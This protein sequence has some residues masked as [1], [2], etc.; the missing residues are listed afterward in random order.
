MSLK[1]GDI[2]LE[3]NQEYSIVLTKMRNA[4]EEN[5]I[6][7]RNL[8]DTIINFW[9]VNRKKANFIVNTLEISGTATVVYT[10]VKSMRI[11]D[12]DHIPLLLSGKRFVYDE[13]ICTRVHMLEVPMVKKEEIKKEL[14]EEI[15]D[16]L[17]IIKEYGDIITVLPLRYYYGL[18]NYKEYIKQVNNMFLDFFDDKYQSMEEYFAANVSVEDIKNNINI[19][20][21]NHLM[22]VS[23]EGNKTLE[24]KVNGFYEGV[25]F[26]ESNNDFG[27]KLYFACFSLLSQALDVFLTCFAC[28]F[29]PFIRSHACLSNFIIL[30]SNMPENDYSNIIEKMIINSTFSFALYCETDSDE[31]LSEIEKK[32]D[33][34][35]VGCYYDYYQKIILDNGIRLDNISL[36]FAFELSKRFI[37]GFLNG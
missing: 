8:I 1:L 9:N 29:T 15:D 3:L 26:Y 4:L 37:D 13:T 25:S 7:P 27:K 33:D 36:N 12:G 21:I 18:C 20:K 35:I 10:G 2:I 30:A 32:T 17:E 24:E 31:L 23:Y 5:S 16:E 6:E 22:F 14:K 19:D 28:G 11:L 34:G